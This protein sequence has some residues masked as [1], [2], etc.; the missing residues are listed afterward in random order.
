MH[1][2]NRKTLTAF[3]PRGFHRLHT[4]LIDTVA[5]RSQITRCPLRQSESDQT[6][7]FPGQHVQKQEHA[8]RMRLSLLIVRWDPRSHVA[9]FHKTQLLTAQ[10]S[11][12]PETSQTL[13]NEYWKYHC[14]LSGDFNMSIHAWA[15]TMVP[16]NISLL[17]PGDRV[18]HTR[19]IA[20]RN[21]QFTH[22]GF[23][24]IPSI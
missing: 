8:T 4:W 14:L 9:D 10:M 19:L 5:L 1:N 24:R 21:D 16:D 12:L 11:G 20:S 7:A 13:G 22:E 6:A 15:D 17:V 23:L 2:K 3:P 18:A